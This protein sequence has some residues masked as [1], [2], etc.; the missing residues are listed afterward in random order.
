MKYRYYQKRRGSLRRALT[1]VSAS[2]VLLVNSF[3]VAVPFLLVKGAAAAPAVVVHPSSLNGWSATTTTGGTVDFV[4]D[5][6]APSGDGALKLVTINDNDSRARLSTTAPAGTQVSAITEASYWSKVDSAS[7]DAGSVSMYIGIDLDGDLGTTTDRTE[8]VHEPYWQNSES[9]DPA[10]VVHGTWQQWDVDQG[11]FWSSATVGSFVAGAGGPPFYD[12]TDAPSTA[13]VHAIGVYIGS[14]NP[15]Y[16]TYADAVTF[17]G[18]AYDFEPNPIPVCDTTI[19]SFD[20]FNN[21]TVNGQQGWSSTGPFD[22][23]IVSNT[24]GHDSFGCKS[25]RISNAVTSGSFGDQTFSY[26]VANE[27]GDTDAQNGGMSGGTRQNHYEAQFDITPTQGSQQAGLSMSVSPDRGDGAR[28]SYLRFEDQADGIHVFFDDVTGTTPETISFDEYEIATLTRANPHTVK[29]VMDF[30]NGGSNDVVKIYIDG[31]L[32]HTGTSWENYFRYDT[33]SNPTLVDESRTVDSLL[34]RVGGTAAPANAGKGFLVDNVTIATSTVLPAI[35]TNLS[36]TPDGGT[37][38]ASGGTTNVQK[39]TLSWQDTDPGVDH[40]KYYFWTN[41]PGYFEGQANAWSTEGSAYITQSPGGGSIWTDFYDKEGTYYFCVKAIDAG[42]NTSACSDTF[43][44]TY[45]KT[46]PAMPVHQSPGDNAVINYN[47]FWFEWTD[48]AGATRYEVQYSQNP[49]VNGAGAFQNVQWTGDYQMI[50][51]TDSRARS[52]GANG[53]WYWQVRA[54]DA[55]GN[56]SAWTTPWKVTIDADVPTVPTAVFTEDNS[57]DNVPDGGLT[58]SQFFTFTLGSSSDVTRYQLK[59]WNDIPG[60]PYKAGSEWNPND[61]SGYSPVL[62]TYKDNF[63][64]GDGVH[65]FAFSACDAAGNC[66]AYGAPFTVT[67]DGT[68]P[69]VPAHEAPAD[70]A[71]RTTANQTSVEWSD[72]TDPS[73]V[74]YRYESSLSSATNP[75]GSFTSPAYVSG[76][77]ASSAIP[78]PG[79]PE[80]TYYWHVKAVD[81]AGNDSAW[82]TSWRIVVD[83]T[84]P[85]LT[86]N[87]LGDSEDATPTIT[88][89]TNEPTLPVIATVNGVDY[90]ATVNPDG[91]WSADVT[92]PLAVGPYTATARSTDAAGNTQTPAPTQA[93]AVLAAPQVLGASTT[94]NPGSSSGS[95]NPGNSNAGGSTARTSSTGSADSTGEGSV[96]AAE[97]LAQ[98]EDTSAGDSSSESSSAGQSDDEEAPAEDTSCRKLLG[99]CWYWWIPVVLVVL[100]IIYL[101]GRGRSDEN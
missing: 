72:V 20:T 14:Y 85:V 52:V 86:I 8:L 46:A 22:Q 55:A 75:G 33:E 61:L 4:A 29:F 2:L 6:T 38:M 80:G 74:T 53:T 91:T 65:Y 56:T 9:P 47:D 96:L 10:P 89:T 68:A 11:I 31:V 73:G 36:W 99:I 32:E 3:S 101:I 35:P 76:P 34:F 70:G 51:P 49:A 97:T 90:I 57:G 83:N 7:N 50:Q 23:A 64:Q 27:A 48:A 98:A 60:S 39:G 41:I 19:S 71:V 1:S 15:A 37:A 59:Y 62:G 78:T 93:F 92:T 77:L 28:M 13:V 67:Y 87:P 63:T 95:S 84:A 43:S 26:S 12:L 81:G 82:S 40:Y 58:N 24:Y 66:S 44:V 45:D 30:Y 94:N 5:A 69:A 17:N 54:V 16:T 88:G 42:G 18:T 21:G 79:T 25:L 100:I